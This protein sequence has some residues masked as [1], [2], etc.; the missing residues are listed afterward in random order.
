MKPT[1]WL[2]G[3]ALGTHFVA[4]CTDG[5]GAP[6]LSPGP[7]LPVPSDP[8]RPPIPPIPN[9]GPYTGRDAGIWVGEA[10]DWWFGR[11]KLLLINDRDEYRLIE[12]DY[13][14]EFEVQGLGTIEYGA[15]ASLEAAYFAFPPLRSPPEDWR[16]GAACEF[17]GTVVDR[18]LDTQHIDGELDCTYEGDAAHFLNLSASSS[19][20]AY[21]RSPASDV[22]F[23]PGIFEGTW[24]SA[25]RPG[26]NVVNI[27]SLGMISG[28]QP[29]TGCVYEGRIFDYTPEPERKPDG[30]YDV[31]WTFRS[32][33]DG[34]AVFN[35][36]LFEGMV[37]VSDWPGFEQ[38]T[39][40]A[41]GYVNDIGTSLYVPLQRL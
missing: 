33:V 7:V 20:G 32:C 16:N 1:A 35:D 19:S 13:F 10:E 9:P 6:D 40:V 2:A 4:A 12:L 34:A 11:E 14:S 8:V 36:N 37:F 5:S 41:T 38:L 22:A 3:L 30:L 15:D 17:S 26:N 29:N 23:D 21:R 28:Q 25:I 18:G 31:H 39:I 27:D 24:T